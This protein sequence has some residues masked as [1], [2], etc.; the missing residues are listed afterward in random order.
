MPDVVVQAAWLPKS[1]TRLAVAALHSVWLYDLAFAASQPVLRCETGSGSPIVSF[2]LVPCLSPAG[3]PPTTRLT[4]APSFGAFLPSDSPVSDKLGDAENASD[5]VHTTVVGVVLGQD[6][7]LCSV[8][9]PTEDDSLAQAVGYT[10][11]GFTTKC[12]P[13]APL[14]IR[15]VMLLEQPKRCISDSMHL[16]RGFSILFE[17]HFP[18]GTALVSLP[19]L[20]EF[21]LSIN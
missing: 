16:L 17:K 15:C 14:R 9:F 13:L 5:A 6:G 10:R 21:H 18:G 4:S 7:R 8:S 20:L 11:E 19:L 3:E 12:V 2:A 1:S